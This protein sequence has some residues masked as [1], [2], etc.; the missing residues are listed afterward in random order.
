LGAVRLSR[1][2][3]ADD[4]S[5]SPERQRA[6]IEALGG[7]IVG[8]ATDLDVSATKLSPFDRPELGEWLRYPERYDAVAWARLDRAVRS[9]ADLHELAKWGQIHRKALV[10]ASG[11]GGQRMT[12]DF[13]N[14]PL[15]PVA[16]FVVTVLA[17]AA[18]MEAY[19]IRER[20]R[21]MKLNHRS[22]GRHS[23]GAVPWWLDVADNGSGK[24]LV[25]NPDRAA[26]VRELIDR[27][28]AGESQAK[29]F[30]DFNARAV[31]G[32]TNWA[33][34][35]AYRMLRNP[36][37]MGVMFHDGQVIRDGDGLPV[38]R[39]E[40]LLSKAEFDRLQQALEGNKKGPPRDNRV[41]L[42]TGLAF[43]ALCGAQRHYRTQT[44]RGNTYRYSRC[45]SAQEHAKG[46][47]GWCPSRQLRADDLEAYA[48][49]AFLDLCGGWPVM[50]TEHHPAVDHSDEIAELQAALDDLLRRVEGKPESV[51][52]VY[53]S[54]IKKHEARLAELAAIPVQPE[55]TVRVPTGETYGDVWHRSTVPERRRLLVDGG[56]R[57]DAAP[58][59]D[60]EKATAAE[61]LGD[62]YRRL[63]DDPGCGELLGHSYA[64]APFVLAIRYP[65]DVTIEL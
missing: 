58:G 23:G 18:E 59:G 30:R 7:E 48:E 47:P 37:L 54:R 55:R 51:A 64:E 15:D 34:V 45:S 61:K 28:V 50:R 27:V 16:R 57:F 19:A 5:T 10:F 3:G 2:S 32:K 1:Y 65:S 9:M 56:F 43:C 49:R 52:A 6:A 63:A 53:D 26:V 41:S 4:P 40:A 42:L 39:G 14:G 8:W 22:T 17:F 29:V 62:A 21:D 44:I 36:A 25:L 38:Q 35:N 13:R 11:P 60:A 20:I 12:L 31:G 46:T 24:T 33:R